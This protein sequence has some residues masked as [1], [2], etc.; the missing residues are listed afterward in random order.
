MTY[1]TELQ[2][3]SAELCRWVEDALDLSAVDV[4]LSGNGALT[5]ARLVPCANRLLQAWRSPWLWPVRP[6]A[7]RGAWICACLVFAAGLLAFTVR[8][9]RTSLAEGG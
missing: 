6:P 1:V 7:D 3:L 4:E 9:P 2:T 8:G 5:V